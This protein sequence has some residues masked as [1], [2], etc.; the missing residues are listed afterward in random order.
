MH[1]VQLSIDCLP[2]CLRTN[3]SALPARMH[4]TQHK[5]LASSFG[6]FG[7]RAQDETPEAVDPNSVQLLLAK[8]TRNHGFKADELEQLP[9]LLAKCQYS[10]KEFLLRLE[11]DKLFRSVKRFAAHLRER[12]GLGSGWMLHWQTGACQGFLLIVCCWCI[13]L[14]LGIKKVC[15]L[16]AHVPATYMMH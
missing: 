16:P 12:C 13:C 7:D 9:G 6:C 8:L 1:I 4:I 5:D 3:L 15:S 2:A 11:E 10:K 14:H